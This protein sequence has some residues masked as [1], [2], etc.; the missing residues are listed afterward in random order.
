MFDICCQL[1]ASLHRD[2]LSNFE[3]FKHKHTNMSAKLNIVD[4]KVL[5]SVFLIVVQFLFCMLIVVYM[6][7]FGIH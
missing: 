6:I 3:F 1:L 4:I 7:G 2:Q 5:F